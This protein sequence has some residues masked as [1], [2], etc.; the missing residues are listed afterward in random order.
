MDSTACPASVM[1]RL[2]AYSVIM[3]CCDSVRQTGMLRSGIRA[4]GQEGELI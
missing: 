3:R 2:L 1:P 4:R